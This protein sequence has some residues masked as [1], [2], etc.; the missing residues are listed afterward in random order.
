MKNYK[1][2]VLQLDISRNKEENLEKVKIKV[3]EA[4][5]KADII[6][7]S[8]M[9]NCPYNGKTFYKY[10]EESGGETSQLLSK[11]AL[12]N[13]IIIV[14]GSIPEIENKK[15]YNTSYVYNE[16]GELIGKYRKIHLFD[17]DIKD[18]ISFKESDYIACGNNLTVVDIGPFKIGLAICYDIR[19]PEMI[20]SLVNKGAELIV[21]PAAFNTTTGP[22]HWHITSRTRAVDNQ[23]Y[24]VLASPTR[25][26]ILSYKAYG[27]SLIINPWGN[28][29]SEA[30]I[31]E[32]IIYGEFNK[33]FLTKIRNELPLLKHSKN[34]NYN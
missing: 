1:I 14:G 24:L 23:V 28:I 27:H 10:A 30:D 3:K 5:K 7:L 19:F 31:N 4:S 6:I 2:A 22:A 11:L 18:G 12:E 34:S 15:I 16:K 32:E 9:F 21:I 25:S 8:E 29:I 26:K 33:D 13:K 20:K 17:V